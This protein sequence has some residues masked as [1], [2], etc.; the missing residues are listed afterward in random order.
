MTADDFEQPRGPYQFNHW[1]AKAPLR[2]PMGDFGL[3][4]FTAPDDRAPPDERMIRVLADL[5]A[6]TSAR[7]DAIL[8]KVYEH[9]QM[10]AAAG[11][12][13]WMDECGVP[14]G[15]SRSGVIPYLRDRALTVERDDCPEQT[16]RIHIAPLWELEHTIYLE[17]RDGRLEF[18][19][20]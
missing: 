4:A 6:F 3:I 8:D 20:V 12:A 18:C 11:G 19:D 1:T 14:L 10:I 9:Y 16:A 5:A 2:T 15:L 13:G 7:H 17:R